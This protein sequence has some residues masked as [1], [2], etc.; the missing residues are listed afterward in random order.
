MNILV[1]S[2]TN[3]KINERGKIARAIMPQKGTSINVVS[4]KGINSENLEDRFFVVENATIWRQT[5]KKEEDGKSRRDGHLQKGER[6][7][8]VVEGA[9]IKPYSGQEI[10][11]VVCIKDTGRPAF[12]N[13]EWQLGEIKDSYY[14]LYTK[15]FLIWIFDYKED[16]MAVIEA[17]KTKLGTFYLGGGGTSYNGITLYYSRKFTEKEIEEFKEGSVL[18]DAS[19]KEIKAQNYLMFKKKGNCL[20]HLPAREQGYRGYSEFTSISPEPNDIVKYSNYRSPRGNLGI[21]DGV[22]LRYNNCPRGIKAINKASG[23]LYGD[24][25]EKIY[26]VDTEKNKIE[27]CNIDTEELEEIAKALENE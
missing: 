3:F 20:V 24:D 1:I 11:K 7:E 16:N 6:L 17:C 9:N 26:I 22:I 27:I 4:Y 12:I 2:D 14:A 15:G 18:K 23:R 8:I 21:Y 13:F 25:P 19:I 10:G 5:E